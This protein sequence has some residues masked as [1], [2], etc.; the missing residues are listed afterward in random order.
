VPVPP[1]GSQGSV[2]EKIRISTSPD[3]KIGVL[4]PVRASAVAR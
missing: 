2:T 4:T 3:Q 1:A